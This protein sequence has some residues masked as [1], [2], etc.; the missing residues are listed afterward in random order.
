MVKAKPV[1]LYS[2]DAESAVLD[3]LIIDNTLFD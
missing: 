1:E 2:I 3:G